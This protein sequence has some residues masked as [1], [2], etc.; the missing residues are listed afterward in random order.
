M[1]CRPARLRLSAKLWSCVGVFL[2]C[3]SSPSLAADDFG[4]LGCYLGL[5][6]ANA[7]EGSGGLDQGEAGLQARAGCRDKWFGGELQYEG[8]DDLEDRWTLTVD[9][10]GYP[11]QGRFQPFVSLGFGYAELD[12]RTGNDWEFAIRPGGGLDVYLTRHI[13]FNLNASYVVPM[14]D[15][16]SGDYVSLGWG[17]LYRF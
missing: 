6:G 4:R 1:L 5:G 8:F 15:S 13:A 7:F 16:D 17:L 10:K 11:L 9:A 12:K 14:D 3:T 2:V